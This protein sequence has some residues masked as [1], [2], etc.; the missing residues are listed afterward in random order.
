ME[1]LTGI[2]I[3]IPHLT[4]YNSRTFEIF[5]VELFSRFEL[6]AIVTPSISISQ[7]VQSKIMGGNEVLL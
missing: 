7:T 4:P 1:L 3:I 6:E 5:R 2:T